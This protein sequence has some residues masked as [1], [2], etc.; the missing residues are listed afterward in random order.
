[1][2]FLFDGKI[3]F[4]ALLILNKFINIYKTKSLQSEENHFDY[5]ITSMIE[6][7]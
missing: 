6:S 4:K 5:S 1:M 7:L 3:F 2:E